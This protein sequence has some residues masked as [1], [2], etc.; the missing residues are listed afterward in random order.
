MGY[1]KQILCHQ[2]SVLLSGGI[3]LPVAQAHGGSWSSVNTHPELGAR[4]GMGGQEGARVTCRDPGS[5][6]QQGLCARITACSHCSHGDPLV[7]SLNS[8]NYC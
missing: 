1:S 3:H 6:A 8:Q 4:A 7:L 5:C 2:S